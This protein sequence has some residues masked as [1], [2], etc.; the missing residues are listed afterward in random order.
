MKKR[1][2]KKNKK[3]KLYKRILLFLTGFIITE[4]IGVAFLLY[5]PLPKFRNWLVTTAMTTMNHQYLA[6]MFYSDETINKILEQNKV[7]EPDSDTDLSIINS[8]KLDTN[9]YKNEYEKEILNHKKDEKYKLIN[10]SGKGYS[11]YLVAIYDP[12]KV[13]VVTTKNY[14]VSGSYRYGQKN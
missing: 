6:T 11:G 4:I 5:G 9:T 8:E 1:R 2:R 10:I 3:L 7:I 14:G 12:S 13:K